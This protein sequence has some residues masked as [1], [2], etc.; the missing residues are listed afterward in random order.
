MY[1]ELQTTPGERVAAGLGAAESRDLSHVSD[2]Q[3][4]RLL[5]ALAQVCCEHGAANVTVAQVVERAGVSRRT[6]YEL[7]TDYKDCFLA[8]L[9]DG[10]AQ[11]AGRVVPAYR[12]PGKWGERM[13]ASLTELLLFLDEKPDVGHLLI[14]ETLGAGSDALKRRSNVLAGVVDAVGE[15]RHESNMRLVPTR[16][17]AEGAAGG[18]LSVLHGRLLKGSTRSCLEL[19]NPLMSMV[20]QPYL[21]SAAALRELERPSPI[22]APPATAG[23]GSLKDLQIRLTYRTVKVIMAIASDS[24]GSNRSVGKHAGIADQGQISKLLSRLQRLGLIVNTEQ[25]SARGTPNSWVLTDK[26]R[27]LHRVLAS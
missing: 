2:I 22:P 11:I 19:L 12:R 1:V 8:A 4:A 10:L 3:R 16:L 18:V 15:G 25:S 13:R 24:G 7:F 5:T 6:F 17:T 14:V 20:V 21:G 26:G 23:S 9:D 27:E